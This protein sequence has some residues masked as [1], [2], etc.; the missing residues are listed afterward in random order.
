MRELRPLQ[1]EQKTVVDDTNHNLVHALSVRL[2]A[3]WH[4]SSYGSETKCVGCQRVFE[5]LREID[6]EAAQLL[7]TELAAHVRSNRFPLDI[8]D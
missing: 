1:P 6:R 5:R 2:D 4:D 8:S 7:N 3:R